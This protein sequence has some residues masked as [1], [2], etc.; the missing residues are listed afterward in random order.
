MGVILVGCVDER[1]PQLDNSPAVELNNM[2]LVT[3][4]VD[5]LRKFRLV[6]F[7]RL[8]IKLLQGYAII[9]DKKIPPSQKEG[10]DKAQF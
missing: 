8:Y 5:C 7:S 6:L 4:P 9:I 3:K 1:S 2:E 10:G